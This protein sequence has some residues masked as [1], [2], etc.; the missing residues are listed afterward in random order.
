MLSAA[1]TYQNVTRDL[2]RSLDVVARTPQVTRESAYYLAH[3]GNVKSI[4]D[5]MSNKR[6]LNYALNAFGL[7]EISYATA[8]VRRLL[9]SG[10]DSSS[11]LANRLADS[12]YKDFVSTFNFVR[13]GKTTTTFERTRQG[14]VDRYRQQVLEENIGDQNEGARLALYFQRKAPTVTSPLGLLA[15]KALLT[16]TQ[17]AL[18]LSPL[19]SNLSIEAQQKLIGDK[20]DVADFKD[21]AKLSKFINRYLARY[22]LDNPAVN[23]NTASLISPTSSGVSIG[24]DLLMAIQSMRQG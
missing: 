24:T 8:F 22:D 9:E 11:A 13:Y 19:T 23:A 21:P 2:T 18:G 16:V 17:T 12:R 3:I 4:D 1:A 7:S 20:L 10:V 14:T 15:D 5:L 6:V